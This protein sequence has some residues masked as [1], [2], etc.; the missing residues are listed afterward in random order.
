MGR[1]ADPYGDDNRLPEGMVCTGYDADTGKRYYQDRDGSSWAG[2]PHVQYGIIRPLRATT[3]RE[4]NVRF[5]RKLFNEPAPPMPQLLWNRAQTIPAHKPS[6]T[7]NVPIPTV[8]PLNPDG[9]DSRTPPQTTTVE[10]DRFVYDFDRRCPSPMSDTTSISEYSQSSFVHEEQQIAPNVHSRS[11]PNLVE[12]LNIPATPVQTTPVAEWPPAGWHAYVSAMESAC[13]SPVSDT[14]S[15]E[16]GRTILEEYLFDQ[17]T[18]TFIHPDSLP[19]S[20]ISDSI[21]I[22]YSLPPPLSARATSYSSMA[23]RS[24]SSL[25]PSS[26]QGLDH[27][28]RHTFDFPNFAARKEGITSKAGHRHSVPPASTG[29]VVPKTPMHRVSRPERSILRKGPRNASRSRS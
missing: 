2:A 12:V 13:T 1:F 9:S 26:S 18:L 7:H 28:R 20:P 3:A 10:K 11:C 4:D 16:T 21:C 29:T 15:F 19:S 6:P 5:K 25:P 17:D 22:D 23:N 8:E 24:S 27:R 14:D